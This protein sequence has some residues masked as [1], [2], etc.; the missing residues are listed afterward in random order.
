MTKGSFKADNGSLRRSTTKYSEL[1]ALG[2]FVADDV[3]AVE[4][5]AQR[6]AGL[7]KECV[8]LQIE[9]LPRVN[10]MWVFL[11]ALLLTFCFLMV[12]FYPTISIMVAGDRTLHKVV[13]PV[14]DSNVTV[15]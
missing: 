13:C 14:G 3:D 9:A 7:C 12:W 11:T 5:T 4:S 6:A 2:R 8:C 1:D 15:T 10:C